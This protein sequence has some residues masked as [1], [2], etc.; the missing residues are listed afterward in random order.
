MAT[1]APS[2]FEMTIRENN[3]LKSY[4]QTFSILVEKKD[5]EK[6]NTQHNGRYILPWYKVKVVVYFLYPDIKKHLT[7]YKKQVLFFAR[8]FLPKSVLFL[9]G[10]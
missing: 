9:E 8:N 6:N 7:K 5:T 10:G 3:K 1:A 4:T 2:L